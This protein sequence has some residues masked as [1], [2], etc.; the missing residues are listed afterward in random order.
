MDINQGIK[1]NP[2]SPN[3]NINQVLLLLLVIQKSI[4]EVSKTLSQGKVKY[5]NLTN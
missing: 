3:P 4:I 5:L 2:R 1:Q